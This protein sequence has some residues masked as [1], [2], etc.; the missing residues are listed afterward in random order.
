MDTNWRVAPREAIQIQHQLRN[1]VILKPFAREINYIAGCDIS[2]NRFATTVY[3][4]FVVLSFPELELITHS[5][6]KDIVTFPYIPGLLSFREIPSLLKAWKKLQKKPDL[7]MVDGVGIAHPRRLGI[8]SHL[9]IALDTPTIGCAK[10]VLIGRYEEPSTQSGSI[11]YM[12]DPSTNDVIG[13]AVRTKQNIKP[14]Y[15]SPG[16]KITLEESVHIA[17]QCVKQHRIPE[18]TRL[19]HQIVNIY[20]VNDKDKVV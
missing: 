14:I 20:R 4:G 15:I 1:K 10:S 13:A 11:A 16:H 19:A 7:V 12:H 2:M 3:A 9:G 18:P 6:I 5:V 17:L 8:A